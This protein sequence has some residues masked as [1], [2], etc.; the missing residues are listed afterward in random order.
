MVGPANFL[1]KHLWLPVE[2][3]KAS[4]SNHAFTSHFAQ[5]RGKGQWEAESASN[6]LD[7]APLGHPF[8]TR[9]KNR[10]VGVQPLR[11]NS[12]QPICIAAQVVQLV[13][14]IEDALEEAAHPQRGIDLL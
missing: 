1:F 13:K 12:C 4:L 8:V 3:C 11:R 9:L 6:V 5:P 2:G 10:D 14:E 7:L